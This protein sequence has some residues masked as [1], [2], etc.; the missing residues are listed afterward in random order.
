MSL[1]G[2]MGGDFAARSAASDHSRPRVERRLRQLGAD[3]V[4]K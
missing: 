1:I 2:V 4:E 3:S